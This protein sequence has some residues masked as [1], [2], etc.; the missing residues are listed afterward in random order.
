MEEAQTTRKN[1]FDIQAWRS[2]GNDGRGVCLD[3]LSLRGA[4]IQEKMQ[5]QSVE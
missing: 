4:A 3:P 1:T 2:M 5:G